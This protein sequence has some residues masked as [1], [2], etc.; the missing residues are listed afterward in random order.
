MAREELPIDPYDVPSPVVAGMALLFAFSLSALLSLLPYLLGF[1]VLAASLS[2]TAMALVTGGQPWK[3]TASSM[4]RAGL[5]QPGL[6]GL[7]IAVTFTI[8]SLNRSGSGHCRP[9]HTA[10]A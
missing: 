10:D 9:G 4:L 7:A 3:L 6:G 2:I 1:P 8:G 5:R